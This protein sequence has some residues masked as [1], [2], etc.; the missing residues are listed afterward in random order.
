MKKIIFKLALILFFF[1]LIMPS[2]IN[3]AENIVIKSTPVDGGVN[4]D[5]DPVG[6]AAKYVFTID[7]KSSNSTRTS[8][9]N[10]SLSD[11]NHT[12]SV[13][14][15]DSSGKEIA[16]SGSQTIS[17]TPTSADIK[18]PDSSDQLVDLKDIN[19]PKSKFSSI[20][21]LAKGIAN[22]LFGFVGALAT[23]AIVYSGIMYITAG[24][25][26][27][28]AETAKKN[29]TWAIIGVAIAILAIVIVNEIPKIVGG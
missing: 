13:S 23:I 21:D 26:S 1:L 12:I 22:L 8:I 10:L 29:L 20:T 24:S 28:K 19:L 5:W 4:L 16:T 2:S 18:Q 17:K 9:K 11:G 27:A 25:D 6:G 3:A 14:A 15:L 7:G